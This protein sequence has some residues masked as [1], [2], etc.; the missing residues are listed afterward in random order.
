MAKSHVDGTDKISGDHTTFIEAA[1]AV[2]REVV[3]LDSVRRV[4][5]GFI[6]SG[7]KKTQTGVPSFKITMGD[8]CVKLLVRQAISVQE[9]YIYTSNVQETTE[10]VARTA[11]DLDYD[12]HFDK[13][14]TNDLTV[15]TRRGGPEMR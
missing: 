1:Q 2:I 7:L 3:R 9:V 11:R 13:R 5:P 8:G 14:E 12:I 10:L 4:T 15:R 6:Q